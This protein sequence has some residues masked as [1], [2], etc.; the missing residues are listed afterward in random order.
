MYKN[1]LLWPG[2]ST[3]RI[4]G[5][6]CNKL[7]NYRVLFMAVSFKKKVVHGGCGKRQ[8]EKTHKQVLDFSA[9]TNPCPPAVSWTAD[10]FHIGHY[11]DD[12]YVHLKEVIAKTF[13]RDTEEICVGN[14]SMELI[15]VF[16]HVAF[17]KSRTFFT[18]T[19]TFGEY[20]FS[21]LLAG[22]TKVE[23]PT[24]ADI[25]FVCNPNNPTGTLRTRDAMLSLLSDTA[26]HGGVLCADE[27]FIELAD[28]E[29]SLVD[30]NDDHLIVLRS[31]TKCFS[32]P[33]LRF[34][35]GF[36][37]PD[38]ILQMEAMRPPW[39]VNACAEAFARAAFSHYH[40]LAQSRHFIER[41]RTWLYEH[42]GA[43]GLSCSPSS[44]NFLLIDTK[45]RSDLL[46][47]QLESVDIL[48][49]DCTSFGLPTTIRIAVRTRDENRCLLEALAA[50]L[51]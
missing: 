3:K 51:H 31:L 44:A 43:L 45:K 36:G 33:G 26:H 39:S 13:H 16:C 47:K 8:H 10:P 25:R 38:L 34:G 42:L 22:G 2:P 15:R 35:Y 48:V 9:S 28:P 29:Q 4:Y 11:P 18:E 27:A 46:C 7:G 20:E 37:E 12:N 30:M 23:D 5:F 32:V 50:C 1:F 14:G 24:R 6:P 21:A 49:R 40:E 17:R 41:E 19:P